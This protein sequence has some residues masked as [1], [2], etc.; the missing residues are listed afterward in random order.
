FGRFFARFNRAFALGSERYGRSV[1]GLGRRKAVVLAVYGIL[2]AATALLG[3][4]V[5]GGFVPAQDK[6]YLISF[7]QLPAGAS[8]SRTDAVLAERTEI[9]LREPGV[10]ASPS[11]AGLS[12][13]GTPTSSS[14]GLSFSLLRPFAERRGDGASAQAASHNAK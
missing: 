3:K 14:S 6:E 9:A 2:L 10:A 11:Y 13:H 12:I 7:V 5:P 8:L 1:A 4:I